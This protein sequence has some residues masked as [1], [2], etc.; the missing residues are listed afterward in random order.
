MSLIK[1]PECGGEISSS[2]NVCVH[3]GYQ[4]TICPECGE[5]N[6]K[7]EQIC[8]KCGYQFAPQ[9]FAT[10]QTKG[11]QTDL[12]KLC[13]RSELVSCISSIACFL[14][15]GI[16]ILIL[17]CW[18]NSDPLNALI[19]YNDTKQWCLILIIFA[20]LLYWG[21]GG[22]VLFSDFFMMHCCAKLIRQ[23]KAGFLNYLSSIRNASGRKT[24]AQRILIAAFC[25]ENTA[26]RFFYIV[27]NVIVVLFGITLAIAFAIYANNVV[28]EYM[29]AYLLSQSLHLDSVTLFGTREID[30][31][32]LAGFI[33]GIILFGLGPMIIIGTKAKKWAQKNNL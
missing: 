31:L 12:K 10:E 7:K 13:K 22:F 2:A 33:F 6:P 17:V 27:S 26:A 28:N 11:N 3:C 18:K 19:K 16:V 32:C 4:F 15:I 24:R 20:T 25:S 5:M 30:Y 21:G 9:T 1:C 14:L 8:K 29:T 23:N